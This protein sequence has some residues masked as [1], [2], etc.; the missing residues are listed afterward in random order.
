MGN[1]I[2]S[3]EIDFRSACLAQAFL[4]PS[5]AALRPPSLFGPRKDG[6]TNQWKKCMVELTGKHRLERRPLVWR[7]CI[8][9]AIVRGDDLC[10]L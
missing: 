2:E 1:Y 4:P 7:V 8:N 3:A 5:P 10:R 6:K 9:L